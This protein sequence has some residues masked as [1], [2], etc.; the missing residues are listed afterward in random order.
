MNRVSNGVQRIGA[1]QHVVR[2]ER[3]EL[4]RDREDLWIVVGAE[5][6]YAHQARSIGNPRVRCP[7][8]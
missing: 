8:M 4:L 7:I 1:D 2:A 6:S 5:E 3:P